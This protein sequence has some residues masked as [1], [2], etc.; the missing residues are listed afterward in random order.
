MLLLVQDVF[1]YAYWNYMVGPYSMILNESI[2][3]VSQVKGEWFGSKG[4][5][6]P[7]FD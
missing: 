4:L 1:P 2:T 7:T 6:R 5:K 3:D